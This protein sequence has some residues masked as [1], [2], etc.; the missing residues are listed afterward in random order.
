[1]ITITR[2]IRMRMV[3]LR[4]PLVHMDMPAR[5]SPGGMELLRS[6]KELSSVLKI[7]RI[8]RYLSIRASP[9]RDLR[10]FLL[11]RYLSQWD[12]GNENHHQN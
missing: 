10:G 8:L 7:G 12:D 4:A 3:A 1:M 9:D 5:F 2:T 6:P 11:E